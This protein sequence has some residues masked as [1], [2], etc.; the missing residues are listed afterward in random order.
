MIKFLRTPKGLAVLVAVLLGIFV[1]NYLKKAKKKGQAGDRKIDELGIR[2]D[3]D[4]F[5]YEQQ[6]RRYENI[7]EAMKK[8]GVP[9]DEKIQVRL[10][11]INTVY[12][13]IAPAAGA[14]QASVD[15]PSADQP[16]TRPQPA[17]KSNEPQKNNP[18]NGVAPVEGET[19]PDMNPKDIEQLEENNQPMET[20]SIDA[21]SMEAKSME[22]KSMEAKSMEA[23]SME[24]K[25]MEAEDK[26]ADSEAK[27]ELQK[28]DSLPEVDL[29]PTKMMYE[30]D[31]TTKLS[32]DTKQPDS[33]ESAPKKAVSYAFKAK[34]N[35][36]FEDK[37]LVQS[38]DMFS[39][40][41]GFEQLKIAA[42]LTKRGGQMISKETI[43][44]FPV[45]V[46]RI[47][48]AGE[49]KVNE[50]DEIIMNFKAK[51]SENTK[52]LALGRFDFKSYKCVNDKLSF[53]NSAMLFTLQDHNGYSLMITVSGI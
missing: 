50:E 13:K 11:K 28:E 26:K 27:L 2:V 15:Q 46:G 36:T 34:S 45:S 5:Y 44:S 47:D 33:S 12:L 42:V 32:L 6:K 18:A 14:I 23:K 31:G 52:V 4:P 30:L 1:V 49:F 9:V 8:K 53:E 35:C 39:N 17:N 21:K 20:K 3:A 16:G 37:K 7:S 29:P 10:D 41:A 38:I 51:Q 24:A 43:E 48:F 19:L 40:E 25:P 22:A